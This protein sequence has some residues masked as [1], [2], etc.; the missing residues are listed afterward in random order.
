[1]LAGIGIAT[2]V[3]LSA[4]ALT[5][6][7]VNTG[8]DTAPAAPQPTAAPSTAPAGS[9]TADDKAFCEAIA[10]LM[11]EDAARSK[12]FV[13]LGHTGTPERDAGIPAYVADTAG[14]AKRAQDVIDQHTVVPPDFLLRSLQRYVD[15]VRSYAANIRPGPAADEDNA[16]WNDSLVAGGGAY[17]VCGDLGVPLW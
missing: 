2:A 16:A 4:A 8:G 10:P 11:R 1:M 6:S 5:I 7:I 3:A 12:A 17:E 9:T 13:A 15:D 14:W